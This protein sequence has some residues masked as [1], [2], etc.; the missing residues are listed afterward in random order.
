M[1][2]FSL[3]VIEIAVRPYY[4][5]SI[6]WTFDSE[7]DPFWSKSSIVTTYPFF[8]PVDSESFDEIFCVADFCERISWAAAGLNV[9]GI[10]IGYMVSQELIWFKITWDGIGNVVSKKPFLIIS[11]SFKYWSFIFEYFSLK[12]GIWSRSMKL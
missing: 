10:Y 4:G 5:Y 6:L 12:R 9:P 11:V 7:V 8:L 3:W 1:L 2:L